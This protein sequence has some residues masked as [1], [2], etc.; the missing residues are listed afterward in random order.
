M[1][2]NMKLIIIL[3][4]TVVLVIIGIIAIITISKPEY[5]LEEIANLIDKSA[6]VPENVYIKSE[7]LPSEQN[8]KK[9]KD[10]IWKKDNLIRSYSEQKIESLEEPIQSL[11]ET[12]YDFENKTKTH[13]EHDIKKITKYTLDENDNLV[14]LLYVFYSDGF[15]NDKDAKYEYLGK[16][17]LNGKECIKFSLTYDNSIRKEVYYVDVQNKDI[18]QVEYYDKNGAELKL[19]STVIYEYSYGTVTDDDILKFDS[20]NYPDYTIDEITQEEQ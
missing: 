10:E 15:R 13:I 1:K 18:I 2:K 7:L 12:I 8:G 14:A 17:V 5:T 9:M 11:E 20:S 16:E 6:N 19:T 4:A 3:L